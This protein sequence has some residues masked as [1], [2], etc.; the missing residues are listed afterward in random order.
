MI[1]M[2]LSFNMMFCDIKGEV[3][4]PGVYQITNNNI[5]DVIILAGGLTKD[6]NV[7]NI[8]LSKIV[9]DEMVIYIPSKKEKNLKC[10]ICKCPEIKCPEAKMES[11]IPIPKITTT[12]V[13]KLITTTKYIT[14]TKNELININTANIEELT[15]LNGIGEIVANRIIS[16]RFNSPFTS[17]ED[18]MNVQGIGP[19]IF[20]KIKDYIII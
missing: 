1:G 3:N 7:N 15:T 10:S 19:T 11:S 16:Y 20:A 5:M 9:A 17:I 13:T 6:A 14:T 8:N 18:I 12:S 4:N 2:L